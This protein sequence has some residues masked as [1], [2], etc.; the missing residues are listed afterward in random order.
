MASAAL[1]LSTFVDAPKAAL[2]RDT[3][4][5]RYLLLAR[6]PTVRPSAKTGNFILKHCVGHLPG[7]SEIDVPLNYADAVLGDSS[8]LNCS[9]CVRSTPRLVQFSACH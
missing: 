9:S 8:R 3:A 6:P 5:Q 2:Y 4:I 1:E 7:T